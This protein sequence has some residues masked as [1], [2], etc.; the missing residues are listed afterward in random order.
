MGSGDCPCTKTF[1]LGEARGRFR[2]LLVHVSSQDS[3]LAERTLHVLGMTITLAT[4]EVIQVAGREFNRGSSAH[5]IP[6]P[7]GPRAVRSVEVRYDDRDIFEF[8][9]ELW[10]R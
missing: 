5:V 9:L 10:A 6:L 1:E 7:G 4:G 8:T 3:N 2:E